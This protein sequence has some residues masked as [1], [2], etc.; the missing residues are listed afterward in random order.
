MGTAS[1]TRDFT[2]VGT[3][4]EVLTQ[5]IARRVTDP[6]PVNLAFGTRVSLLE[7]I[8]H[9]EE[10]LGVP[11]PRQH[12]DPRAGDVRDSQADQTRVRQLFPDV[13][14]V[15]LESGLQATVSWFR[16]VS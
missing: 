15:K 3:V 9:L 10:V 8:A 1:K 12:L 5:A 6:Q 14:P 2:Y 4:A 16:G 13:E 11:L 7:V